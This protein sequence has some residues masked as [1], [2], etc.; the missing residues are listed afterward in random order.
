LKAFGDF[1]LLYPKP[2]QPEKTKAA[3]R[4]ALDRGADPDLIVKAAK[5]YAL[6]LGGKADRYTP[7]SA[8][9]LNNGSY[10]DPLEPVSAPDGPHR[11][12]EDDSA[13]H[14]DWN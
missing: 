1:W 2:M 3:W 13:Y 9:W 6:H 10:E 5:A 4:A 11:N 14:Q 7:Y 8:T 12:P